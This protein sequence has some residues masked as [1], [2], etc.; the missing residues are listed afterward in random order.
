[1]LLLSIGVRCTG[2]ALC[3]STG[4]LQSLYFLMFYVLNTECVVLSLVL[5]LPPT[6]TMEESR[7]FEPLQTF[8][9][10]LKTTRSPV[11]YNHVYN[12]LFFCDVLKDIKIDLCD[13]Y[14]GKYD[15]NPIKVTSLS[16]SLSLSGVIQIECSHPLR[17]ALCTY[18][19][20]KVR[21]TLQRRHGTVRCVKGGRRGAGGEEEK[22]LQAYLWLPLQR[23]FSLPLISFIFLS[24]FVL[25]YKSLHLL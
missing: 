3:M 9:P 12:I 20:G 22:G 5:C 6:H 17:G 24:W 8:L 4:L 7:K 16:L 15:G 13:S 23:K 19:K 10:L 25:N 2:A 1:M 11:Q 21:E 14:E 18:H